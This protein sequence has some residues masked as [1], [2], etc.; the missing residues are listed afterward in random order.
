MW[1]TT[2]YRGEPVTFYERKEYEEIE[3]KLALYEK[4]MYN[5][6]RACDES[7]INIKHVL[8]EALR[9][10]DLLDD[11]FRKRELEK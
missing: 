1:R 3:D 9:T 2:N 10:L 6:Y 7:P 8:I 11:F 4:M 5:V